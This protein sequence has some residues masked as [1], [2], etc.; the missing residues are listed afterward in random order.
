MQEAVVNQF[1]SDAQ[2]TA[3]QAAPPL[4]RTLVHSSTNG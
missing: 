2:H 4:L 1:S 3:R